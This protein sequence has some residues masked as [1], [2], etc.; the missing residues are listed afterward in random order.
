[1][2]HQ[3]PL[4]VPPFSIAP[5]DEEKYGNLERSILD[6]IVRR[7]EAEVRALEHDRNS[8]RFF[9]PWTVGS[10]NDQHKTIQ[11]HTQLLTDFK[12]IE[13]IGAELLGNLAAHPT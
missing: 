4:Y 5:G 3:I 8:L 13:K 12:T 1:M 10:W 2:A 9:R 6:A 7:N 11:F